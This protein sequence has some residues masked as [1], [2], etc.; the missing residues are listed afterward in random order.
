MWKYYEY[1]LTMLFI[2][3]GYYD[4]CFNVLVICLWIMMV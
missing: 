4:R 2:I 1:T 3:L